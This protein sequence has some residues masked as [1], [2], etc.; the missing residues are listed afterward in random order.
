MDETTGDAAKKKVRELIKD[1]RI[2]M[3]ATRGEDGFFHARPMATSKAE[4][5]GTLWFLTDERTHKVDQ[6]EA[7]S[8]VLVTYTDDSKQSYV[9][10]AGQ[11]AIVRDRAKLKEL[12]SEPAR[13]WFPKGLEDPNLVAMRI[14]VAIAEYWDVPSG[15]LVML[16]GYLK[17]VTTGKRAGQDSGG[18]GEHGRTSY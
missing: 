10:L 14:D 15:K 2:A 5:D 18:I 8:E 9:S 1:A 7:D 13:A 4:F 16:F 6:L 17:A 11:G 3:L 12:W